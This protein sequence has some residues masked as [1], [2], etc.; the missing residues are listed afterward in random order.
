MSGSHT[1]SD[2]LIVTILIQTHG[3]VIKTDLT[4][5]ETDLFKNVRLSCGAGDFVNYTTNTIKDM[6]VNKKLKKTFTRDIDESES[7]YKLIENLD[8]NMFVPNITFDKSFAIDEPDGFFS[9]LDPKTYLTPDGVYLLSIHR[10][11]KLI[12]PTDKNAMISLLHI[13]NLRKLATMYGKNLPENIIS[14]PLP[15]NEYITRENKVNNDN[16]LKQPEKEEK[17]KKIQN[18][19]YDILKEWKLTINDSNTLITSIKLSYFISLIKSIISPEC[20]INL[21]DYSCSTP[22]VYIPK[23]LLLNLQYARNDIETGHPPTQE[24]GGKKARKNINKNRKK[25]KKTKKTKKS[26]NTKKNTTRRYRYRYRSS[27][28]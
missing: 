15:V 23:E 18:E 20:I 6:N 11:K 4:N 21:L 9:F 3:T 25:T 22:S 10:G 16:S 26:K 12:Y 17:I 5:A 2:K 7:T 19:F 13:E 8:N 1:D 28:K 27:C 24:Y 14:K